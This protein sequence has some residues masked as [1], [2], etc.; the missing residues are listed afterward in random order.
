MTFK[1]ARAGLTTPKEKSTPW[2]SRGY[3]PHFDSDHSIQCV[4]FRLHDA[5]P[6]HVVAGRHA[7]LNLKMEDDALSLELRK[8]IATYED[9]GHGACWLQRPDIA[10]LVET[11]LLFFDGDRY[12]LIAWC[13]MPNHVHC[14]LEPLGHEL[15][16]IVQ[17]WKSYTAKRANQL[18]GRVGRFWMPDYYDRYVRNADHLLRAINYAESNPVKA[19]IVER[20]EEYR[21][22]SAWR[23]ANARRNDQVVDPVG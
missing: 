4:T 13:V 3:L 8:R 20:K 2:H 15:G 1:R 7:E 12:R 18:L 19:R 22:S 14:V 6:E 11:A 10:E 16:A 23:K 9:Q 5:V 21:W 17:S